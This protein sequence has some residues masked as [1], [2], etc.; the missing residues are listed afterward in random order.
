LLVPLAAAV[1]A[2]I[3]GSLAI[4]GAVH[5]RPS[6]HQ[7]R[8]SAAAALAVVPPYYVTLTGRF[9]NGPTRAV[10][11]ATATGKV[12]ATVTHPKGYRSGFTWVTAAANDRSSHALFL[13]L[14]RR[15]GG[16][17]WLAA[18]VAPVSAS[19]GR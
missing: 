3:A 15:L 8:T 14:A 12:L 9:G 10:V 6:K 18:T 13:V 2:V 19:R 4:S 16:G 11:R 17:C 1:T 7:D 5:A